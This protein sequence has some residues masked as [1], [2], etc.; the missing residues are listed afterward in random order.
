MK[1]ISILVGDLQFLH[2]NPQL[3]Q[4]L[5]HASNLCR[6]LFNI[7][8]SNVFFFPWKSKVPVKLPFGHFCHFFHGWE[9]IFTHAF[10]DFFTD[11]TKFSRTLFKIFSRIDI[12]FHG[13][14][15]EKIHQFW[16]KKLSIFFTYS[17]FF[18]RMW[19]RRNFHG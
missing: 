12:F 11:S 6:Q 8:S 4:N 10:Y 9:F 14:K 17:H 1:N 5:K 3:D 7:H 18:S 19:F 13:R 15:N 2:P 16:R